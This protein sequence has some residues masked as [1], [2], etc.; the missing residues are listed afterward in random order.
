M[1]TE[2]YQ[3]IDR[4]D[5]RQ[6]LSNTICRLN[7]EPVHIIE[8][9]N[10]HKVAAQY[11]R[12]PRAGEY[13]WIDYRQPGFCYKSPPLG[14]MNFRG[15]AYYLARLPWREIQKQGLTF[16]A[17]E[18]R[19]ES[20]GRSYWGRRE[21]ADCICGVQ[22]TVEDALEKVLQEG[23]ESYAIR[24]HIAIGTV[25]GQNLGVFYRGRMVGIREMGKF[26]LLQS[27]ESSILDKLIRKSG[28][29]LC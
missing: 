22:E 16:E 14:Y 18:S 28:V 7:G 11:M 8:T 15:K 29:S 19:P 20:P 23:W 26:R 6:R 17:V 27:E 3:G 21:L 12:G 1:A 5:V 10:P 2:L 9:Q 25:S 24:R 4:D 13:D